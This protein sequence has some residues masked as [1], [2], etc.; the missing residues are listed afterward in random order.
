VLTK[1]EEYL[2]KYL[3]SAYDLF[4]KLPVQHSEDQDDFRWMIH[5]LQDMVAARSGLREL[6]K[7]RTGDKE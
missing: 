1:D 2:V 5:R 7:V 4:I 6:N 3:G